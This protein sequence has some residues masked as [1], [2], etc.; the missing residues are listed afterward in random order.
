MKTI[1]GK[2]A[3]VTGANR[4]LGLAFVQ[5]LLAQGAAQIYAATRQPEMVRSL[6]SK[7]P[8]VLPL[9]L[10]L[11]DL[12]S[13]RRAAEQVGELHLLVN[14]AAVLTAGDVLAN[15][16][17]D[18]LQ[19][20]WEVNVRG[21]LAVVRAFAPQLLAAPEAVLVQI[22]SIAA[23]CPFD[24]VPTYAATKSA[25]LS[26]TQALRRELAPQGVPVFSVL[27][28]PL[29]TDMAA[30]LTCEKADPRVLAATVLHAVTHGGPHDL[31]PDAGAEPFWKE[32]QANPAGT[33][34]V[35]S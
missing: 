1:A 18:R 27:P 15:D 11:R 30:W 4:G 29:A 8:R 24:D 12:D 23:L 28:G 5:E 14:N 25:A 22:N 3:L 10:E 6:F 20:E 9:P 21:N 2:F 17:L 19:Q 34:F 35:Q 13:I 16:S 32:F 7:D 33:L 31:F 26:I